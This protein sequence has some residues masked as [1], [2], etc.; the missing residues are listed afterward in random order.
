MLNL[1]NALAVWW[2]PLRWPGWI[3]SPVKRQAGRL[4]KSYI[5]ADL[6]NTGVP[7]L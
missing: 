2:Q 7:F 5:V 3:G 6:K 4:E 1:L